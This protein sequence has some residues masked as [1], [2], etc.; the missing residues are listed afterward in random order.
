MDNLEN[1][2]KNEDSTS[3]ESLQKEKKPCLNCDKEISV[4]A[5]FCPRCG[6]KNN[7][8]RVTMRE[9]FSRFWSNLTHLD[10]KFIKMCWQLFLPGF[11]TLQY[12]KGRHKRYPHPVQFFFI[13]MFFFLFVFNHTFKGDNLMKINENSKSLTVSNDPIDSSTHKNVDLNFT[14]QAFRDYQKAQTITQAF[15]KLP[16]EFK[17]AK[18][19]DALDS[20]VTAQNSLAIR[21]RGEIKD[22]KQSPD[23]ISFNL[24]IEFYRVSIIDIMTKEPDEIVNNYKVT[25]WKTKLLIKQGIKTFKNPKALVSS[26]IGSIS[27][28]VIAL[29]TTMS[30]FMM[31]LYRKTKPFYVEHF[32]FLMHQ[33]TMHFF[34]GTLALIINHFCNMGDGLM[35]ILLLGIIIHSFFAMKSYYKQS[36]SKTLLKCF[37]YHSINFFMFFLLFAIGFFAVFAIF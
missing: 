8:G 32:V 22:N 4:K 14:Y 23:S 37:L 13:V 26:Y 15:S 7:D 20:I 30:F 33:H 9:L 19:Q 11:V 2:A 31:L 28:A 34:L 21:L 17:T 25:D 1:S 36:N 6:Q 18:S 5:N 3:N 10:S 12:F 29:I 16:N 27:W 24:G 35:A